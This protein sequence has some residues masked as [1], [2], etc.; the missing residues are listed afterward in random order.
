MSHSNLDD[1]IVYIANKENTTAEAVR[2]EMQSAM[3]AAQK[4]R[5]PT[6]Q[7]LWA[8]IPRKGPELTLEEFIA[9]LAD[10][11]RSNQPWP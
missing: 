6:A 8:S 3:E 1:I 5:N 10:K 2:A 4:S 7:A 11:L 9:F